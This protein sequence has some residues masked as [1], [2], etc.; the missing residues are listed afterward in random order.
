M[1]RRTCGVSML[2][3]I[4]NEY[5]RGNLGVTDIAGNMRENRLRWLGHAER[6]NNVDILKKI[7]ETRVEGIWGRVRPKKKWMEV[8]KDHRQ[9]RAVNRDTA[10]DGEK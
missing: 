5:M 6:R 4:R 8:I 1:L 2:D 9:V 7:D 10:R 3:K